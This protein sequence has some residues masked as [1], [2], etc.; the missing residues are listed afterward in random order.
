MIL[1]TVN[2][3]TSF[4]RTSPPINREFQKVIYAYPNKIF[5]VG[6]KKLGNDTLQTVIKSTDGGDHWNVMLDRYGF[7]LR[8]VYFTDTLHGV[9]VGDSG[10]ILK[11]TDGGNTWNT[12]SSPSTSDLFDVIF[13]NA[14]TGFIVG[15]KRPYTSPVR[16]IL[17][18][19]NAGAS[20]SIIKEEQGGGL[21]ALDFLNDSVG[22]A[23]GDS[24]SIFKTINGGVT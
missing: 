2:S 4:T 14:N 1:K 18:T 10:T 16:T 8:S 24:A 20:W 22:Y 7:W 6:G 12:I 5:I 17:K 11:T 19:T 15:G 13:T 23:V 21:N 3:G 9:A